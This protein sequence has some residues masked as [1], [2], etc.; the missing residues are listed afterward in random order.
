VNES[1]RLGRIAG[2]A[3]GINWSLLVIFVLVAAGL[4]TGR[5]PVVAPE[6]STAAYVVAGVVTALLFLASVLA[7]EVSHAVVAQRNGIGVEGIVLWLFGGVAKMEREADDP[8]AELRIAGVGPLVSVVLGVASLGAAALLDGLGSGP[9]VVD[10][11]LWLG[12]INVVLA[13]FNLF[14]GAPLDG[15]R[16]LRAVLWMRSGDRYRSW[17]RAA[18]AGRAVGF[19]VIGLGIVQFAT[20]GFGGLWLVLIGWFLL[21]A[22]RA[23]E[24]HARI[25]HSLGG[26][27]VADVMSTE[28]V[29][30]P[31]SLSVDDFLEDYVF[32][33]RFATFPVE[34][35]DGGVVGLATVDRVKDVPRDRRA[36]V[37]VGDLATPLDDVPRARPGERM[38]DVVDRLG[39]GGDGRLLVLD[40]AD[41]L[42]GIVSPVDVLRLMELGEL[43]AD[44]RAGEGNGVSS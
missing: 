41:H 19:G 16:V 22:A 21:S 7:H 4:A 24:S 29:V 23:E 39:Q 44:R 25:Q 13:V 8:G 18:R 32:H 20:G 30:A 31:A 6:A 28:P 5:F 1:I 27:R 14:P 17:V 35:P 26:L 11:A 40:D 33:H 3:V 9:L 12:V 37:A 36:S 34:T 38:V 43:W 15:G 10:A 42:V 2:V